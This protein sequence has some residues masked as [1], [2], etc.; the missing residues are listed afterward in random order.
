MSPPS[1]DRLGWILELGHLAGESGIPRHVD[2]VVKVFVAGGLAGDLEQHHQDGYVVGGDVEV[3]GEN[4]A[5]VEERGP[6][7]GDGTERALL[8]AVSLLT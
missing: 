6:E 5:D 1:I 2:E 4:S 3:T 8:G 7:L